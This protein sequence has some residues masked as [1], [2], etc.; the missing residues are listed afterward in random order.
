[1]PVPSAATLAVEEAHQADA[2]G[3]GRCFEFVTVAHCQ[4]VRIDNVLDG[5]QVYGWTPYGGPTIGTRS[6]PPL[7][8][9][10]S[11]TWMP[12]LDKGQLELVGPGT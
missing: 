5:P 9:P 7:I 1:M 11:E 10:L 2:H 8:W 6:P 4:H 12:G 3:V